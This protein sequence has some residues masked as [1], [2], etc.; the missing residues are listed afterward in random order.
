[1]WWGCV[2]GAFGIRSK[3]QKYKRKN[4]NTKKLKIKKI[5]KTRI[6]KNRKV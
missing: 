1:M 2:D 3:L 4:T 5:T 6:Q